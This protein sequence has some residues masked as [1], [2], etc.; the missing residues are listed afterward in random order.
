MIRKGSSLEDILSFFEEKKGIAKKGSLE[1]I[2][3]FFEDRPNIE[4]KLVK[5]G[6]LED[7]CSVFEDE[8][9]QI[10]NVE[11][12]VETNIEQPLNVT[13]NNPSGYTICGVLNQHQK[14]CQRIGKCPFHKKESIVNNKIEKTSKKP[15]KQGWSK[16]EHLKFL[17]GLELYGKGSWKQISQLV[18]T[19]S[20]TQI[21]SHAQKYFLRQKQKNKNKKSIHDFTVNDLKQVEDKIK[22]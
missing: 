2:C 9:T 5:K 15:F 6:S 12:N 18:G 14:P 1:D 11:T 22:L 21:Q 17:S 10:V 4:K 19:R 7:I 8:K 20:P 13:M 16:E 3:S